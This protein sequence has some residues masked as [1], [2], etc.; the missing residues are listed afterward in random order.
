MADGSQWQLQQEASR[1]QARYYIKSRKSIFN[2][3]DEYQEIGIHMMEKMD[4][5]DKGRPQSSR[6]TPSRT[7]N[8]KKDE[9][10]MREKAATY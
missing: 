8:A 1:N 7:S 10:Y 2:R 4:E 6:N 9:E 5:Y 3:G